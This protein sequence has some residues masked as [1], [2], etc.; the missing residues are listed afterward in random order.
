MQIGAFA[1]IV[2]FQ[3][4]LRNLLERMGRFKVGR[5][6]DFASD[7]TEDDL[8]R[9]IDSIAQAAAN[10]SATKTGALI[11]MERATRL[12][13]YISTGTMLDANVSSG[14]LENI[15][16]P[17][18]PLHDGAVIIRNNKIVTAGC[19]LPLTANNNLSRDLGTRH[20]AAIGL[21]EV[22]D[23]VII[24]VSE[25]T[26]KISIALNG[27]LT[28]NLSRES[29]AKAL[30][31]IM[32]QKQETNEKIDK[33][34]MT[35][36][37]ANVTNTQKL[38]TVILSVFLAVI[39]WFMVI[40]VNDPD[41]TTTV[42][43]LNVRFVGEMSLRD[44]KLA[45]TGKDKIPELSVVVTGK[46]S[47]LMNFMDD[48][49][50]QVDVSDIDATGEYNLSGVISIPTTR[51]SVEKEKYG[52]IP[53]TVEPLEMKDIEVTVKQTGML[54]DK[55]V[56]SSVNNPT[57]TI[58]GAKSEIDEVAGAIATVDVSSIQEDG[59]ENVNYLLTDTN[60]ELINKNETIESARSYVEVVNTIY[61]A[62]LLPVV[63]RLSAELD[64]EYI[65][66][67]DK[68]LA[69]PASVTVGVDETNT[70]DKVIAL[71]DKVPSDGFGEYELEL[72]SGMYIPEDNKKVKYKLDIV[73]KA[74]AQLELTVQAQNVQSGLTAKI[75]NK[76]IAQVW[77]EEGKVTTDNVKA[78]VDVSGLGAGTYNLPVKIEGENVSFAENYTIEVTVE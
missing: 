75:N 16:V 46:R 6:I 5:I 26:G 77:G 53:I 76:L 10:M 7:T 24:V 28:R 20:R 49:Y 58:T 48:I 29:L 8:H 12:G 32:S 61:D 60:G 13:E 22:T 51:I 30:K 63:P 41:I 65:L 1:V 54:K 36:K 43:D 74:V 9:V 70:D 50:V 35:E 73:K 14:L 66:K 78:Y 21:S 45:V 19:L 23:A 59:V 64:K 67:A 27:S 3:P 17:N 62:K 72:S 56:K 34:E 2:I 40:Y 31:K 57:V 68:S 47:D 44:K 11:V 37:K 55:I 33:D 69:T 42:S 4:E 38:K 71:I 18:T 39:V 15:F 25:E 52:D